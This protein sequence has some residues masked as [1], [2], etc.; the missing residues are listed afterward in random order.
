M[1]GRR[2]VRRR[3]RSRSRERG[4]TLIEA[5]VTLSLL[6]IVGT[7]IGVV[8]TVGLR[9]ILM[10]GASRDRLAAASSSMSVEQLLTEDAHR[11]TCLQVPGTSPHGSC[12]GERTPF[13]G[14]CRSGDV[15]C[16]EWPDLTDATQCDMTIYTLSTK[17]TVSR[18]EWAGRTE[19]SSVAVTATPVR[20]TTSISRTDGWPV[21]LGVTVTSISPQL[22]NPAT[23]SFD[24]QPLATEPWPADPL[25]GGSTGPC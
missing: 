8:F 15:V 3:T 2:L 17:N 13:D 24:L 7:V 5:L 14:E 12:S 10:P 23:L 9:S 22:A 11:A 19:Q 20:V 16:L 6:G 4:F 25:T 21:A 1:G 18:A